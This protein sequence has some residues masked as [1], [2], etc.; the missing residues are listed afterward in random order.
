MG[1]RSRVEDVTP[2]AVVGRSLSR[3]ALMLARVAAPEDGA[4]AR[5]IAA[6]LRRP[7]RV[8]KMIEGIEDWG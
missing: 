4:V 5:R 8:R 2:A 1:R 3:D 6:A 7:E